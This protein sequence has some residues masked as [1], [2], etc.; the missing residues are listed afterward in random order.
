MG[1]QGNLRDMAVADLIQHNCQDSKTARL[2]LENAG[3]EAVLFFDQGQVVHAAM[4][5]QEGEK[6]VFEILAWDEGMFKLDTGVEAPHKTV[7]RSWSGLLMEGARRLDEQKVESYQTTEVSQM[8]QKLND[9]LKE[10]SGEVTGYLASA[11][12]GMDGLSLAD[13][14]KSSKSN[15][16]TISAQLALLFKLVDTST[17]KMNAGTVE[18][19]LLTTDTAYV[20][21][22]FL[23]SKEYFLGVAVDRKSGNLGNLR[24]MSKLYTDRI[25]K[26]MPK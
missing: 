25:A 21:M 3:Q 5:G 16:E 12:V 23:P 17:A 18:D 4:N 20:L 14:T 9:V 22:R 24:L 11:V 7:T 10:L 8:A 15:P 1:M 26:A 19:N 13:H 2:L 6:V